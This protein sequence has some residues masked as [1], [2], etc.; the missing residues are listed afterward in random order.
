[1][2]PAT[3]GEILISVSGCTLPVAETVWTI[4]LRTA[5]SVVTGIGFS[6]FESAIE[7][8]SQKTKKPTAPMMICRLRRARRFFAALGSMSGVVKVWCIRD[9]GDETVRSNLTLDLCKQNAFTR[10][11]I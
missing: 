7:T 6:R 10:S 11:T 5:F 4:V 3:S 1:I 2:S 8:I 9:Q